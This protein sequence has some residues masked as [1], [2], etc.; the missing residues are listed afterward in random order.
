MISLSG[1][2]FSVSTNTAFTWEEILNLHLTSH[3]QITLLKY[4]QNYHFFLICH[5]GMSDNKLTLAKVCQ[6]D[7]TDTCLQNSQQTKTNYFL[8]HLNELGTVRLVNFQFTYTENLELGYLAKCY[9]NSSESTNHEC[10][11]IKI[12]IQW[13]HYTSVPY[14]L[15]SSK[16]H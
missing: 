4:E 3:L 11:L 2:F 5:S 13:N 12:V 6:R 7:S 14:A 1:T 16:Y 9:K 10:M 8:N 15:F